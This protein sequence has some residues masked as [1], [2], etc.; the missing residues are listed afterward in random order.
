MLQYR[1]GPYPTTSDISKTGTGRNGVG[2][3]TGFYCAAEIWEIE[4]I[5]RQLV[6]WNLDETPI[7]SCP[8]RRRPAIWLPSTQAQESKFFVLFSGVARAETANPLLS[9]V[10]KNIGRR[11]M[12]SGA[13][14]FL[15]NIEAAGREN[16]VENHNPYNTNVVWQPTVP[17][18][19]PASA[20]L[21]YP[22]HFIGKL[23]NSPQNWELPGT[24][25]PVDGANT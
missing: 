8:I 17:I 23:W 1:L 22:I 7:R 12:P 10:I 13:G 19:D 5:N 14:Y 2:I 20:M 15:V 3:I 16:K 25:L 4:T 24:C 18:R 11:Y 9:E 6:E 21:L